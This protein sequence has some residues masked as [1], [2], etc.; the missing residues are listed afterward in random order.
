[1]LGNGLFL[2]RW[3]ADGV[4]TAVVVLPYEGSTSFGSLMKTTKEVKDFFARHYPF[5][6]GLEGPSEELAEEFLQKR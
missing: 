6:F 1:P 2:P 4:I 5:A 3:P